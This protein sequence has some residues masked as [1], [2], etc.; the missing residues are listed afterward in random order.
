M[1]PNVAVLRFSDV[2]SAARPLLSISVARHL[3]QIEKFTG[4]RPTIVADGSTAVS[5]LMHPDSAVAD[6]DPSQRIDGG[7]TIALEIVSQFFK[8]GGVAGA[9]YIVRYQ[10]KFSDGSIE[11]FDSVIGVRAFLGV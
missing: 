11:V 4:V 9:D 3:D 8:P 5:V 2:T 10:V 7:R 6:P 1:T